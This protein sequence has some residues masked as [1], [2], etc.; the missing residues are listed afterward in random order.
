[1]LAVRYVVAGGL[2]LAWSVWRGH[3]RAT[4]RQVFYAMVVGIATLSV[5][6]GTVAWAEKEITSGVAALLVTTVPLWMVFLDWRW[7]GGRRPRPQ[8]MLGLALGLAGVAI[9]AAPDLD[10]GMRGW[11]MLAVVVG[12]A[13]WSVGSMHSKRMDLPR[14]LARSSA[15]QMLGGGAGML[16]AGLVAG[17]YSG[18][19]RHAI[20]MPSVAAL[21]YLILFGSVV[22]FS[23]Y[24]WLLAHVPAQQIASYAFVNPVVAVVLGWLLAG[25]ELNVQIGVA[26]AVLVTSV[27]LIVHYGRSPRTPAAMA[28]ESTPMPA[29]AIASR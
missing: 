11:A 5:G 10:G 12:S 20:T 24:I 28:V 9:L 3:E 25:E 13:F 1:M 16:A 15:W 2:I 14:S 22:A 4:L 19:D 29:A 18:L 26:M 7:F 6:T 8:V 21:L 23:A 27:A 17:E